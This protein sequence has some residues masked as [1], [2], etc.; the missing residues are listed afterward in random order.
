MRLNGRV[1][2]TTLNLIYKRYGKNRL[3]AYIFTLYVVYKYRTALL[4]EDV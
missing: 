2:F 4:L 1:F 3:K